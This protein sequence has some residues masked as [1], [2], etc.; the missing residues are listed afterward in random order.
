M[1][2][3]LPEPDGPITAVSSPLGDVDGDAAKGVDGGLAASV[4]TRQALS[5]DHRR[6]HLVLR[7][8][9]VLNR[10]H[11]FDSLLGNGGD[12]TVPALSRPGQRASRRP[13]VRP[14]A[15]PPWGAGPA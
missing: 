3:D 6:R 7:L 8:E 10:L 1:S 12:C 9:L 5:A 15:R 13:M 4:A 2:V 11:C 14:A